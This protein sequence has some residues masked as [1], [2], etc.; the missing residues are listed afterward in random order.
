[1]FQMIELGVRGGVS[2]ISK[3][4]AK[5]D[6]PYVNPDKDFTDKEQTYLFLTDVCNL[7]GFAMTQKL[8]IKDFKCLTEDEINNLKI[9]EFPENG[10][11][12]L[13][14]QVDMS[15]PSSLH[16]LHNDLPMAPESLEVPQNWLSPLQQKMLND[17]KIK[18]MGKTKKLIPH[19]YDRK[20]YVVHYRNLQYYLAHG[21]K[22][23][24][25]HKAISFYQRAWLADY[26]NFNTEKRK[27]AKNNTE[28]AF[29]KLLNN[30]CF[31]K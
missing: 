19:L 25:I 18:Y 1:M 28:I 16:K 7:Y 12:G 11:R 8:P 23:E 13:I 15:Y 3:K 5:A 21:L 10:D 6:N 26:I 30:A 31:G 2:L 24:K 27:L 22:L 9:E 17:R 20:R 4:Y 14:L 29:F